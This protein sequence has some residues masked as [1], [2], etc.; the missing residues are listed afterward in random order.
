MVPATTTCCSALNTCV[1]GAP[2]AVIARTTSLSWACN[3]GTRPTNRSALPASASTACSEA[4]I[5]PALLPNGVQVA[6]SCSSGSAT[7]GSLPKRDCR[8]PTR[9]SISLR[10]VRK[11]LN[12]SALPATASRP[13]LASCC[14]STCR[15]AAPVLAPVRRLPCQVAT[16]VFTPNSTTDSARS[17]S[18]N[19]VLTPPS[20]LVLG[21][22]GV[23]LMRVLPRSVTGTGGPSGRGLP[24]FGG[25]GQPRQREHA[26]VGVLAVEGTV[27]EV[28][29]A[30]L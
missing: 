23:V 26:P 29:V 8:V 15:S 28:G 11:A 6:T 14:E 17:T 13:W 20:R 30:A 7:P 21:V 22:S 4:M 19:P 12:A 10:V 9:S 2:E 5:C 27:D 1:A 18:Q 25:T 24:E 16:P 3:C